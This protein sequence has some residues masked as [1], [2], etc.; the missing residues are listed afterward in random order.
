MSRRQGLLSVTTAP[1][2]STVLKGFNSVAG[3]YVPPQPA[4]KTLRRSSFVTHGN[5]RHQPGRPGGVEPDCYVS[6]GEA[7]T[8]PA[9]PAP[10]GPALFPSAPVR[11]TRSG[12]PGGQLSVTTL[13]WQATFD[14]EPVTAPR[15][16]S[17]VAR[18]V[19]PSGLAPCH[20]W[21]VVATYGHQETAGRTVSRACRKVAALAYRSAG[22][23]CIDRS[24]TRL[25]PRYTSVSEVRSGADLTT[26]KGTLS[27]AWWVVHPTGLRNQTTVDGDIRE[28][29]S[30]WWIGAAGE[31]KEDSAADF[32]K[33]IEAEAKRAVIG[34]R[35]EGRGQ[36][37]TRL[38]F[39]PLTWTLSGFAPSSDYAV[40]RASIPWFAA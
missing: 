28:S 9:L 33:K 12:R 29:H 8:S 23:M 39:Y 21:P 22:S 7:G 14:R 37:L 17:M 10:L 2:S 16:G 38:A 32:C 3:A 27:F 19:V 4:V 31:R 26:I 40:C 6:N 15:S 34:Q 5:A 24:T 20:A 36:M 1:A 25:R 11:P 35:A 18:H 30:W 13:P